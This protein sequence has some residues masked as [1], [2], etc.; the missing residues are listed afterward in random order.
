M[1]PRLK[2]WKSGA[3]VWPTLHVRGPWGSLCSPKVRAGFCVQKSHRMTAQ[4][5]MTAD[6]SMDKRESMLGFKPGMCPG[7]LISQW[8]P[9]GKH[10]ES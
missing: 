6:L 5:E 7:K 2:A 10:I 3:R 4:W 9:V 1:K 8:P